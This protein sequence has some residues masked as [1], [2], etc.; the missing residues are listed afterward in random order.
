[1]DKDGFRKKKKL[2][3]KKFAKHKLNFQMIT[4]AELYNQ[5]PD[6]PMFKKFSPEALGNIILPARTLEERRKKGEIE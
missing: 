5:R 3:K 1:M 2:T 4:T 6:D